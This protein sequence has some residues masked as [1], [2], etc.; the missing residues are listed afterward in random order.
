MLGTST[1]NE[2]SFQRRSAIWVKLHEY[3]SLLRKSHQVINLYT[4][5]VHSIHRLFW[6]LHGLEEHQNGWLIVRVVESVLPVLNF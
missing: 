2:I 1:R 4:S 3:L 6:R 5:L